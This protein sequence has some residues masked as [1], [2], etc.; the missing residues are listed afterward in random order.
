MPVLLV[1]FFGAFFLYF[2]S[3]GGYKPEKLDS[4]A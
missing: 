4:G 1:V 2:Q 3:K